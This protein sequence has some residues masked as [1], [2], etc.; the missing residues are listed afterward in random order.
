M[1]SHIFNLL[2]FGDNGTGSF[3]HPFIGY[4]FIKLYFFCQW[5]K[6]L[7]LVCIYITAVISLVF[8][9]IILNFNDIFVTFSFLIEDCPSKKMAYSIIL[10]TKKISFFKWEC[11]Q[12]DKKNQFICP[13][14]SNFV[15]NGT[16]PND[17]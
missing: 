7:S 2:S 14:L 5:I 13:H 15:S 16:V 10:K 11:T 3:C 17:N 12:S 4:Y 1:F 9:T 6:F 8:I